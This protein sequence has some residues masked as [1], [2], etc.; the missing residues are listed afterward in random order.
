MA[1]KESMIRLKNRILAYHWWEILT[2]IVVSFIAHGS[3]LFS[4]AIGIDME[5]A[6]VGIEPLKEQGRHG[7][8]WVRSLLQMEQY[9]LFLTTVLTFVF[10]TLAAIV[11]YTGLN[12]RD[13]QK[14]GAFIPFSIFFLTSPFWT[15]QLYFLNQSVPVLFSIL[16][17]PFTVMLV[18]AALE[19]KVLPRIL[20][21]ILAATL[22]QYVVSTYQ[23]N[24]IVYVAYVCATFAVA[25]MHENTP[26]KKNLVDLL[27]HA[28]FVLVGLGIYKV[29]TEVFYDLS[30]YITDQ[31]AW[32]RLG[33]VAGFK[34]VLHVVRISL[35]GGSGAD[36]LYSFTYLPLCAVAF[37]LA[38][39]NWRSRKEGKENI[40]PF[41]AMIGL[42]L[43]PYFFPVLY[44]DEV[45][46][47]MRYIFPV[48]GAM[49][50]Y[51]AYREFRLC[52]GEAVGA[53][54]MVRRI[55]VLLFAG[56]FFVDMMGNVNLTNA[57]Y[58][59]NEF[60]YQQEYRIAGDLKRDLE[61]Y[62]ADEGLSEDEKN[63]VV[64]LGNAPIEY[65]EMCKPDLA[66][67]GNSSLNWDSYFLVRG[68]IYKFL[69]VNG[70]P[71]GQRPYFSEGAEAAYA[72]YFVPYFGEE[73]DAMPSYPYDGYIRRVA[74]DELGLHY[75][76]VKLGNDWR[77]K[78]PYKELEE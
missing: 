54:L 4:D 37:L 78:Y 58:Y 35:M 56:A 51:I 25:H 17:I 59:T 20:Y 32:S 63:Y 50:L 8:F 11:F 26:V 27:V 12:Q 2:V 7:I 48:A 65:N 70:Y 29:I 38:I 1:M 64:F 47:R 43:S 24:V 19:S 33:F 60:R 74:D 23:V 34:N 41:I 44:G 67:I 53:K 31:I 39:L 16:L 62:L 28:G 71:L 22:F 49:V 52:F 76:V 21:L 3:M 75:I 15:A 10:L 9:N 46:P 77:T 45:A 5:S 69:Q 42:F 36:Q 66:M 72:Y 13:S 30:D 18:D 14:N 61:Q 68:R 6:I 73:V 57:L 55:V 40:V